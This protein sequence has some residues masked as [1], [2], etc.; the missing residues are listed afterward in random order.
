MK[1]ERREGDERPF[2]QKKGVS[3]TFR[4]AHGQ[5]FRWLPKQGEPLCIAEW[6]SQHIVRFLAYLPVYTA[7][8]VTL[9]IVIQIFHPFGLGG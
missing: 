7:F 1:D 6:A 8:V 2:D 3:L 9:V 5:P 4:P